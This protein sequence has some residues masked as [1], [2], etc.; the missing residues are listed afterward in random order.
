MAQSDDRSDPTPAFRFVLD[1]DDL[2][3]AGFSECTGLQLE[4]ETHEY[5]E[6]GMNAIMRKFPGH[7]KQ[8]N[9]TLKRG[10]VDRSLWDWFFAASEGAVT[11]RGGSVVLQDPAGGQEVMRWRFERAFPAKLSGPELNATQNSVAVETL[12]LC[13]EGLRRER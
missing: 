10:I 4:L 13:H 3:V 12:E 7:T 1:I 6:G 2:P 5:H 9:L 11:F 8:S